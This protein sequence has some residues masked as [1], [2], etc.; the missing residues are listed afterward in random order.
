MWWL[1]LNVYH[2][3]VFHFALKAR[4]LVP[5]NGGP[6]GGNLNTKFGEV[7]SFLPEPNANSLVKLK[8]DEELVGFAKLMRS[9]TWYYTQELKDLLEDVENILQLIEAEYEQNK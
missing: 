2:S 1:Q 3:G 7:I 6:W 5:R 4:E 9:D 8:S